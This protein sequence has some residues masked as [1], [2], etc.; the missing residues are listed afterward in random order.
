MGDC[1]HQIID[2]IKG[3]RMYFCLVYKEYLFS[4]PTHCPYRKTGKTL[5]I[6]QI[7]QDNIDMECVFFH[8]LVRCTHKDERSYVC[9]ITGRSPTCKECPFCSSSSERLNTSTSTFLY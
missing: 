5:T 9:E 3:G 1:Q 4:C 7:Y 2:Q 6:N 8:Q